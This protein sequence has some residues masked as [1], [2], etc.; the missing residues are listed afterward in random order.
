MWRWARHKEEYIR[1]EGEVRK[2]KREKR[3]G[4]KVGNERSTFVPTPADA[5]GERPAKW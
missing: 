1:E 3:K 4:K 5:L 2:K